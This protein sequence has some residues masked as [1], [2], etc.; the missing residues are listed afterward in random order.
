MSANFPINSP[1][2]YLGGKSK[3]AKT[4]IKVMPVHQT[5]VEVFCGA[6]W[7]LFKK[8][9]SGCEIINDIN[10]ELVTMY[11]VLKYHLEEFVK[12]ASTTLTSRDEYNALRLVD[13]KTLTDVQRA[14]R[15]YFL[16]KNSFGSKLAFDSFTV[17][18]GRRP[19]PNPMQIEKSLVEV[20]ERILNVYIEN[21]PYQQ[22]IRRF[23]RESVL[24]YID[25]PYMGC[26]GDYGKGIFSREDFITLR[27]M[28]AKCS[29]RF[30]MSINDTP[31]IRQ[32]YSKF[33][34][35]EVSTKYSISSN[36]ESS[37]TITELLIT[38][39]DPCS[40]PLAYPDFQ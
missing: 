39:Y 14:V 23:D 8:P 28:L 10:S 30:V 7:V 25:P 19:R 33:N 11:R 16:V 12:Y 18:H 34:I 13:P 40:V 20:R 9:R 26:E 4:I 27:D 1:L 29:A 2:S 17:S 24:M 36:R 5:Y 3:L 35:S 37:E 22:I 32:I 38:N 15:Y 21:S 6:A 31:E